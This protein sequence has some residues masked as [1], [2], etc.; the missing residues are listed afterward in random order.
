MG[1][2]PTLREAEEATLNYLIM[3]FMFLIVTI[4][5]IFIGYPAWL[6]PHKYID[7]IKTRRTRTKA[8]FPF[9]PNSLIYLTFFNGHDKLYL[10]W[11]KLSTLIGI[12]LGLFAMSLALVAYFK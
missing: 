4:N 9:I 1:F 5:F 6:K 12:V 8:R 10:W 2:Q 3:F 11:I 7:G